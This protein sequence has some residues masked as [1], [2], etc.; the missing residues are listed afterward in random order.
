MLLARFFSSNTK[1]LQAQGN[2]MF[3][4]GQS[5]NR[6]YNSVHK[7]FS[8]QKPVKQHMAADRRCYILGS[9]TRAST[10][11]ATTLFRYKYHDVFLSTLGDHY[12]EHS[13]QHFWAWSPRFQ[14]NCKGVLNL[15]GKNSFTCKVESILGSDIMN[16]RAFVFSMGQDMQ[17]ILSSKRIGRLPD[18]GVGRGVVDL[19]DH[20]C[21]G[22]LIPGLPDD[23]AK[24]IVALAPQSDLPAM[25]CVAKS[26]NALLR[27]KEFHKIRRDSGTAEKRLYALTLSEDRRSTCWKTFSTVQNVWKDLAPLPGPLKSGSGFAVVDGKLLIIGGA[28]EGSRPSAVADV[29]LYDTS[30]NRWRKVASMHSARYEF[31]CAVL[32]GLVYVVG[33]HGLGGKNLPHVEVYDLE[34]DRWTK[35][36]SLRRA[37]WGCIGCGLEGKLYVMAGRSSFTIGHSRCVDV[38]DPLKGQWEEAKNGCM[39]VLAHAIVDQELFCIEWKNDRKLAVFNAAENL[40]KSVVLP[41]AG[42]LSVGFYLANVNGKL[43]LFPTST[44]SACDTLIY[45]PNASS[46]SEWQTAEIRPLGACLYCTTIEA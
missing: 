27:S 21:A 5:G 3:A 40:W 25:G 44:E 33:G 39:M 35:L 24:S 17:D 31:A 12:S 19:Q 41:L 16:G 14:T 32:N 36:P 38:F 43:L 9:V 45:D 26:W 28:V 13:Y 6:S 42:S 30:L 34:Q 8:N 10:I 15:S 29:L 20:D 4:F 46:G 23:V 18:D 37:R 1:I 7:S 22:T 11:K 2:I